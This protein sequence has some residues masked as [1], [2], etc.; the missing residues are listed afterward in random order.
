MKHK[1]PEIDVVGTKRWYN[2]YGELHRLSGPAVIYKNGEKYWYQ[3]D[4]RHRL[5]GPAVI[6]RNG[7]EVWYIED[8][9]VKP[10]PNIIL[11]LRKKLLDEA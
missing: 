11:Q 6:H 1:Q 5:D 2:S 10:I 8:K 9:R 4:M 3:C 7:K